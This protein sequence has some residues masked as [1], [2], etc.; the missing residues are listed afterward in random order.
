MFNAFERLRDRICRDQ[1]FTIRE[2]EIILGYGLILPSLILVGLT[3]IY[4]V[5]YNIYL[6]FTN[7]P[8]DPS[9]N[10]RW[11]G[12]ENYRT[13]LNSD[14][15]ARAVKNTFIFTFF[16]DLGATLS[17]LAV[18]LLFTRD[19]YG[20]RVVRGLVLLP[21]IA[22]LIATAFAWRWL[23]HPLYGI[24]TFVFGDM[25]GL[26]PANQDIRE[27]IIM[28][29]IYDTWRYF[30]FAFLLILARLQSIPEELYEA[31]KIDGAGPIARFKDITLP[32]LKFVLATVF[33]LRWI[34][35]FNVF[36]DV[37]LF[38]KNVPVL[39]T[40]V[41]QVGFNNY[42]QGLAAATAMLM[43]IALFTMVTIYVKYV[44]DW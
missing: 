5:L 36:A 37:W 32:E 22:P 13:L 42:N 34:W 16:S 2:K 31:A 8:I 18:A 38:T 28:V 10:P 39:G 43:V 12:L 6:S 20:K 40:F 30:P 24:G 9:A 23:W 33:L 14:D 27:S 17:G 21:Y 7:V 26:F 41:Y 44:L 3:L 35:N 11:V 4:P 25:M 1:E 19:F 29:I 15:F